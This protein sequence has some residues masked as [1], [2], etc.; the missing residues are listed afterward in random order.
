MLLLPMFFVYT[1]LQ[2][3]VGLLDQPELWLIT[4]GLIVIAIVGKL[5]GAA[6][7]ARVA[8]ATGARRA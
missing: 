7:A 2:T 8:A 3:N 6:I 5:A 1:G 4:L